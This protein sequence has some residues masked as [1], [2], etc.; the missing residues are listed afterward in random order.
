L[1]MTTVGADLHV[2]P[3]FGIHL[4]ND[5]R[6]RRGGRKGR[7]RRSAPTENPFPDSWDYCNNPASNG[8]DRQ[9]ND[10]EHSRF[11]W[12]DNPLRT[13]STTPHRPGLSAHF[14]ASARFDQVYNPPARRAVFDHETAHRRREAGPYEE[15]ESRCED[16]GGRS[17]Q[18][19]SRT[20]ES[21]AITPEQY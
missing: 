8:I 5:N 11:E 7:T 18:G 21:S 6:K 14:P 3:L 20:A 15:P 9:R 17:L 1:R 16:R 12:V 10:G 19:G 4:N 13:S 2:R